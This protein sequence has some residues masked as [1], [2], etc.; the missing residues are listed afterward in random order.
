M[1]EGFPHKTKNP[2][3]NVLPNRAKRLVFFWATGL[4]CRRGEE[5]LKTCRA[6]TTRLVKGKVPYCLTEVAY[7][8]AKMMATIARKPIHPIK[9]GFVPTIL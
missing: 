6:T 4:P 3:R 5:T 1:A 7:P 9:L 2:E 8:Q